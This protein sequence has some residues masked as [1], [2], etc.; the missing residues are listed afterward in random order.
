MLLMHQRPQ[1][2]AGSRAGTGLTHLRTKVEHRRLGM[3]ASAVMRSTP[4]CPIEAEA[5]RLLAARL[6]KMP[7]WP[8]MPATL[9]RSAIQADVDR[10]WKVMLPEAGEAVAARQRATGRTVTRNSVVMPPRAKAG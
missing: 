2:D 3:Y 6:E 7:W 9:R 1:N 5:R 10:F 8:G 4:A